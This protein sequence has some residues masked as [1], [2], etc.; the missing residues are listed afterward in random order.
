MKTRDLGK[1]HLATKAVLL[2]I[3][4]NYKAIA[5]NQETKELAQDKLAGLVSQREHF[6]HIW[7]NS[8]DISGAELPLMFL[9]LYLRS[10][11]VN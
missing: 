8:N 10:E 4:Q 11:T 1:G 7:K 3:E 2:E 5:E 6:P 9:N